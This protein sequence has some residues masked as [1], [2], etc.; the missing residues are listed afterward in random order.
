MFIVKRVIGCALVL[1]TVTA[2]VS[3]S[4]HEAIELPTYPIPDVQ[5]FQEYQIP[6]V[7]DQDQ[8]NKPDPV[9]AHDPVIAPDPVIDTVNPEKTTESTPISSKNIDIV[10]AQQQLPGHY[11]IIISQDISAAHVAMALHQAPKTAR[12]AEIKI[13]SRGSVM[14]LGVY[15]TYINYE[16]AQQALNIYTETMKSSGVIKTW[17]EIQNNI[18]E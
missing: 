4:P 12:M 15:G 1:G 8:L 17:S 16:A 3:N 9:I 18:I 10:W 2:C 14:Y 5:Q 11:T 13:Q 6:P 7:L